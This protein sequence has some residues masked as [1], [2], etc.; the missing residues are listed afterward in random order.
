[1]TVAMCF[2]R[3]IAA[4]TTTTNCTSSISSVP[5]SP[6]TDVTIRPIVETLDAEFTPIGNYGSRIYVRS[7]KD[8]PNRRVI[9]I[10]LEDS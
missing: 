4:P 7:D 10:D 2:S 5:A 9:A 1:M 3:R 6:R 8:A